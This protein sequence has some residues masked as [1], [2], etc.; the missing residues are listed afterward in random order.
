MNMGGI[1]MVTG[2]IIGYM[3]G[4]TGGGDDNDD[5]GDDN[6]GGVV[7]SLHVTPPC[8]TLLTL[9]TIISVLLTLFIISPSR[10]RQTGW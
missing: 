1:I 7:I 4:Q 2:G 5:A 8:A 6:G 3:A 9:L 10:G